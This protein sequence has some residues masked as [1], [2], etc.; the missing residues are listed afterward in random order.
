MTGKSQL[1]SVTPLIKLNSFFL[2]RE[3][4]NPSGSVKD[5]AVIAQLAWAKKHGYKQV[6][7]STSG[8]F[9]ISL[10]FWTKRFDLK[11]T[12]FVSPKISPGKIEKLKTL[13]LVLKTSPRPIT[14][15]FRF[16]KEFG[17]LNLRQSKDPRAITGFSSLGEEIASQIKKR[18]L[19]PKSIFFPV[20]SGT[21]LLGV[22]QGLA[23]K[24]LD[25]APFLVQPA[26]HPV[27]AKIWDY[28]FRPE[29]K[30]L[31]DALTAKVIPRKPE[32]LRLIKKYQGGGVV[33]QNQAI[34]KWHFWLKNRGINTS[35]E[36]ALTL[37]GVEKARK[38]RLIN[39]QTEVV[40]LL[41]GKDYSQK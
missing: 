21:T 8:N 28:K 23:K 10:G 35:F 24:G 31:A 16:C 41:T 18:R 38:L 11:I 12:V 29:Q 3:D 5:R 26:N 15:C 36:G 4:L 2:K 20:S 40:C 34:L 1:L 37:A 25:L 9:G 14:A 27:L 19:N 13:P 7:A 17:A 6:A 32:I 33:V 30:R 39:K 22:A